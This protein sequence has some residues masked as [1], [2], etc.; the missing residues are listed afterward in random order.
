MMKV[1]ILFLL[2]S[3]DYFS[4]QALFAQYSGT[5]RDSPVRVM[6][7]NQKKSDYRVLRRNMVRKGVWNIMVEKIRKN[8]KAKGVF[9]ALLIL[10]AVIA[11]SPFWMLNASADTIETNVLVGGSYLNRIAV[12]EQTH[13]IY[14]SRGE[15]DEDSRVTVIDGTDYT[16][17]ALETQGRFCC[18]VRLK[19]KLGGIPIIL[20][21]CRYVIPCISLTRLKCS[22]REL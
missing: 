13:K 22:L 10:T 18:F 14:V 21:A 11:L 9:Q 15:T 20:A 2:D 3:K 8:A 6:I 16:T 5:M 1:S 12:N 4:E 17:T 7:N 19:N